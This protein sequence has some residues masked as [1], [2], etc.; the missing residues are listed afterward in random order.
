MQT[1]QAVRSQRVAEFLEA[2]RVAAEE[3]ERRLAEKLREQR[4]YEDFLSELSQSHVSQSAD[5]VLN[6]AIGGL[7]KFVNAS[8]VYV[9][10]LV[11]P[12]HLKY[13]NAT[14][15]NNFIVDEVL[16]R[17]N[18]ITFDLFPSG[19]DAEEQAEEEEDDPDDDSEEAVERRKK[20]AAEKEQKAQEIKTVEVKDVLI[21]AGSGKVHFFRQ[22]QLGAFLA[23]RIHYPSAMHEEAVQKAGLFLLLPLRQV[24]CLFNVWCTI[25]Y[26]SVLRQVMCL[27]TFGA[28]FVMFGVGGVV[29]QSR[30]RRAF[31]GA[32]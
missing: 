25:C 27:L 6:L 12:D 11:D 29:P 1:E 3:K 17:G 23:A 2:E 15:E 7:Q 30:T 8:S 5:T 32:S 16:E 24:M 20:H 18:G 31:I 14:S 22:P 21:G 10:E 26:V 4:E 19:D 13:I 28:P 9:A